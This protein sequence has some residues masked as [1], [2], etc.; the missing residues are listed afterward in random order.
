MLILAFHFIMVCQNYCFF[1]SK[2]RAS[3]RGLAGREDREE[4]GEG[5]RK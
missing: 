5:D 1:R 3:P 2:E 4:D